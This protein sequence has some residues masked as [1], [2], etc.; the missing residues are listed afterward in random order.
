MRQLLSEEERSF[1]DRFGAMVQIYNEKWRYMPLWF[2]ENEDGTFESFSF[3][4]IPEYVKTVLD[5]KRN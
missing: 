3:E 5:D 2:K 4:A 1:L